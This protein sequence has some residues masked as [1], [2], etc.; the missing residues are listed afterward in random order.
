MYGCR[1]RKWRSADLFGQL[2]D[3]PLLAADL[4][5]PVAVLVALQLADELRAAGSQAGND[6]VDVLDGEGDVAEAPGEPAQ[7]R[8]A[9]TW[10]RPCKTSRRMLP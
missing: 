10:E 4:A 6:G 1:S 9:A 5:E 3:D 8:L 2:D 7:Q